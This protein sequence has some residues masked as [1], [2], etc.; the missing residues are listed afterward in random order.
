[1]RS[2]DLSRALAVSTLCASLAGCGGSG[3]RDGLLATPQSAVNRARIEDGASWTEPQAKR[4]DL[5]YVSDAGNRRVDV[6][7]YPRGKLV[8]RLYGFFGPAGECVDASGSVFIADGS[9]VVEYAH[10]VKTPIATL[11]DPGFEAAGCSVDPKSGNLAVINSCSTQYGS[12]CSGPGSV[13]IYRKARGT[14]ATYADPGL[15]TLTFAYGGYDNRGN[16]FADGN[17]FVSSEGTAFALA[18]LPKGGRRLYTVSLDQYI[19]Y[20]GAVQWDGKHLAVG[21][22]GAQPSVTIYQFSVRH[23]RGTK[24]GSTVLGGTFELNQFWIEG[25]TVVGADY[26]YYD[27]RYW[28]YPAGGSP[29]KVIT[30]FS[31]P[32]GTA[33]SRAPA[34]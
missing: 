14:P 8:G 15:P 30:G 2:S 18:E 16:L 1:M 27:V 25:S 19:G 34:K 10:G 17:Y 32:Y 6:F 21:D 33:I 20:A 28:S 31:F 11:S 29:T 9:E 23:R 5:L 3:P 22:E 24:T 26:G 12:Y 4:R 7:T 13:S